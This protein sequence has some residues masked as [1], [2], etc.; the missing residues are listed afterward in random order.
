MNE[1]GFGNQTA[2]NKPVARQSRIVNSSVSRSCFIANLL[3]GPR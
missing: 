3:A 1:A 2:A